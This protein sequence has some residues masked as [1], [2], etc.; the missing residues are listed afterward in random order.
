MHV[1][2]N[3]MSRLYQE[4]DANQ[5]NIDIEPSLNILFKIIN[6]WLWVVLQRKMARNIEKRRILYVYVKNFQQYRYF[7]IEI[8]RFTCW[9]TQ[10]RLM[11]LLHVASVSHPEFQ[12]II[13]FTLS[14][15][16][17]EWIIIVYWAIRSKLILDW[18][19]RWI[20]CSLLWI[21]LN[22]RKLSNIR[23]VCV[24]QN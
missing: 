19:C 7:C 21:M 11:G 2:F 1:I 8:W 9:V 14:P 22:K 3:T 5:W 12:E 24:Y 17:S 10:R 15:M 6:Y 4:L 13:D 16:F 18:F 23:E 20:Q